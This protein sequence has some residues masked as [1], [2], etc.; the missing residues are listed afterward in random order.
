[1][2]SD[3]AT[4]P[5]GRSTW[6]VLALLALFALLW[7]FW[8][9][10]RVTDS[11]P[12]LPVGETNPP[13]IA[14]PIQVGMPASVVSKAAATSESKTA[15]LASQSIAMRILGLS[16]GS[17]LAN[18]K[19]RELVSDSTLYAKLESTERHLTA[20]SIEEAEWMDLQS[21]PTLEEVNSIDPESLEKLDRH[22]LGELWA[23]MR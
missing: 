10:P 21:F 22:E 6:L 1:M 18:P 8:P 9:K 20:R 11:Q 7:W 17:L 13:P 15:E 5:T 3:N 16:K 23:E 2:T 19:P 4:A 12:P 14:T